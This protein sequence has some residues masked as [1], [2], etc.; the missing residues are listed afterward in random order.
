MSCDAERLT[1]YVDGELPPEES[2]RIAEHLGSCP[3]CREQ[4]EAERA[5][6]EQIRQLPPVEPR[7]GFEAALRER[8]RAARPNP[9]RFL[10]PIA[11][12]LV[13][14]LL[15]A[16]RMPGVV[17]WELARDHDHCFGS[18]KLP[19]ELF[20]TDAD[21][22]LA[23][24]APRDAAHPALPDAAGGLELVGGRRCPLA[25]RRVVHLFYATDKRRVSVFLVPGD[26]RL[27]DRYAI[28]TRANAVL[29]L[30]VSGRVVGIVG[31]NGE[32]VEAFARA[33]LESRA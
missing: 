11:A 5:L 22:A 29:L 17:A 26:V 25:D 19:A 10:L 1:G 23:R 31:E 12:T 8:L 33:L 20:T 16:A 2:A 21:D 9:L 3:G 28:E 7:S 30:R 18:Q 4:V 27:D 32:D 6:R 13:V 24:L 14:T 15:W